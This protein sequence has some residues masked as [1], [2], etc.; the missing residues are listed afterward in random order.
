M[1]GYA[2]GYIGSDKAKTEKT[3]QGETKE[4]PELKAVKE[5]M[6][7][8]MFGA[9]KSDVPWALLALMVLF[10][11]FHTP[12]RGSEYWRGKYEELKEIYDARVGYGD[13]KLDLDNK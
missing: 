5:M 6:D 11:G 9:D 1:E 13:L 8:G 12:D 4:T 10:G 7:K 3:E 2:L